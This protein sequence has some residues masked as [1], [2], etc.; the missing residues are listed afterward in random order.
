MTSP[1]PV[2]PVPL[3]CWNDAPLGTVLALF[4]DWESLIQ[5]LNARR[6][7]SGIS[8]VE[9][10]DLAGL[11]DG[12]TSKVLGP[13]RTKGLGALSLTTLLGALKMKIALVADG[14]PKPSR[15]KNK[16]QDRHAWQPDAA[17]LKAVGAL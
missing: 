11:P 12:Y 17:L 13:A 2:Q 1:K 7:L 4:A 3:E 10:D 6:E 5:S 9:L 8:F 15:Q 14:T 16:K